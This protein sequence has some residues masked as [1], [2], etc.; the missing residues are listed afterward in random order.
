MQENRVPELLSPAGSLEKL[1]IAIQYGADAVYFGGQK[2]GLRAASENF[3]Y[4]EIKEGVNFCH[5]RGSLAYVVINAF[6]FDKDI[7]ELPEYLD[8]LQEAKI[9]AIIAS[10]LGAITTIKKRTSIDVHLSTQASCLNHYSAQFWKNQGVSRI[11]LGREVSLEQAREIKEFTGIELEMF[12]HG[13]MC[14]AYSG[15]CTISNFTQGRDSNRGGCAHSCRFEYSLYS[16]ESKKQ[17]NNFFMSS[18]DL[19]GLNLIPNFCSAK[20]DSVKIE[21]RMKGPQYVATVTKVYREALDLY[22]N[23]QLTG[24]ALFELSKELETFSHRDYAP[25]NLIVSAGADTVY[26]ER[27]SENSTSQI[28]GKVIEKIASKIFVEMKSK[29]YPQSELEFLTFSNQNIKLLVKSLIDI[30]GEVL[31]FT[32]PGQV[33]VLETKSPIEKDNVVRALV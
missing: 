3:T 6:P 25:A 18:K 20:I 21:G 24:E 17:S 2:F 22:R 5:D 4:P 7:F 23:N 29:I 33:I 31:E 14:M 32:K 19:M 28:V 12:I 1:K 8:F 13:S 10:D 11:V 26:D 15:N 27:E 9:D 30:D 16:E